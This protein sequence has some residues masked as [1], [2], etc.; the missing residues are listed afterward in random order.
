MKRHMKSEIQTAMKALI[1]AA[2]L[3]MVLAGCSMRDAAD[4]IPMSVQ[5][6]IVTDD[7]LTAHTNPQ[8]GQGTLDMADPNLSLDQSAQ[9]ADESPDAL[10][11]EARAHLQ[12]R[13][14]PEPYQAPETYAAQAPV[15]PAP[16]ADALFQSYMANKHTPSRQA[17]APAQTAPAQ[18]PE[19]MALLNAALRGRQEADDT[20]STGSI[21]QNNNPF[22]ANTANVKGLEEQA[23]LRRASVLV[24]GLQKPQAPQGRIAERFKPATMPTATLTPSAAPQA[25]KPISFRQSVSFKS[26]GTQLDKGQEAALRLQLQALLDDTDTIVLIAPEASGMR[27]MQ[28]K[29][30]SQARINAL[31]KVLPPHV[32][33][34][35]I[36]LKGV[37]KD[38]IDLR[39]LKQG[40]HL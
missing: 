15:P 18:N 32:K 16:S 7:V 17:P 3:P 4:M 6:T 38:S 5:N 34:Q 28:Q 36:S 19:A 10:L 1:A 29:M 27:A 25:E 2:I 20:L 13:Q 22:A 8:L 11:A 9:G 12:N 37:D 31:S 24:K 35:E 30:K 40:E 14:M 33:V 26:G 21:T 39:I 23:R